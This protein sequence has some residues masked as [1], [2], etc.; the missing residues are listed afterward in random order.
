MGDV[1]GDRRLEVVA[2]TREGFLFVW[3]TPAPRSAPRE[4]PSFRHDARNSGRY[5]GYAARPRSFGLGRGDAS[6]SARALSGGR[7]TANG[8]V[9]SSA[10]EAKR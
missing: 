1:D 5:G 4:W 9:T 2:V 7:S 6:G 10:G 8:S 3:D